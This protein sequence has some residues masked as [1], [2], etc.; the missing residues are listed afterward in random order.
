MNLSSLPP[1]IF[2]F[3]LDPP[4]IFVCTYQIIQVTEW[5]VD[6]YGFAAC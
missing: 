6:V 1:L 5:N 4:L 2:I 3:L